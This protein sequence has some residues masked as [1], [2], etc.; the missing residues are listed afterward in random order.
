MVLF[1]RSSIYM[2]LIYH[3]DVEYYSLLVTIINLKMFAF[4]G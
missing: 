3:S 1:K 2:Y 4:V